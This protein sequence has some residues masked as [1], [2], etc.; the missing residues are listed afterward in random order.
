MNLL[1]LLGSWPVGL[2]LMTLILTILALI[3]ILKSDFKDND[4]IIWIVV[5]L[6]FNFIGAILYFV[7]GRKQRLIK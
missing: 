7:I 4:K 5:V 1:G 6:F 3:E 2:F